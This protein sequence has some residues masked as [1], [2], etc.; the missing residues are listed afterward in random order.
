MTWRRTTTTTSTARPS[1]LGGTGD[2]RGHRRL[3]TIPSLTKLIEEAAATVDAEDVSRAIRE[4]IEQ[5]LGSAPAAILWPADAGRIPDGRREFLFAYL[6]L[7]WAELDPER[8]RE[9]ARAL[10]VA[11]AAGEKG[12]KRRFRNGVGFVLPQKAYADQARQLSR[13]LLALEALRKGVKASKIQLSDEQAGELETKRS[14]AKTDFTGACRSL[15]GEIL[16][17][18]RERRG[19]DP[20]GFRAVSVGTIPVGHDLHAR[21]VELCKNQVY[22]VLVPDTLVERLKVAAEDGPRFVPFFSLLDYPKIRDEAVVLAAVAKA[23]AQRQLGY[24]PTARVD[25][26]AIVLEAGARVRFGKAYDAD[27]F[28]AEEGA[29]FLAPSLA[30]QLARERPSAAPP[31]FVPPLASSPSGPDAAPAAPPPAGGLLPFPPVAKGEKGTVYALRAKSV[32]KQQWYALGRA[33]SEVVDASVD[34]T[35]EVHVKA[36]QPKGFDPVFIA[37]RVREVLEEKEVEFEETLGNE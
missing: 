18:V 3:D 26:D 6:P 14:N 17:P 24:A 27:E 34:V 21:V 9:G 20:I 19:A 4:A 28:A 37:N 32:G 30:E 8:T 35:V 2:L 15:Y 16:L 23:V 22:A 10:L 11:K 29:F 31:S 5:Q 25:G 7:E 1:R 36:K 33:A 13:K 12:G